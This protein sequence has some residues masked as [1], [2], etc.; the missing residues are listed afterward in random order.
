YS[1]TFVFGGTIASTLLSTS[2]KRFKSVLSVFKQLIIKPKKLEPSAA[3]RELVRISEVAQSSSKQALSSEGQGIGDGF[4]GYAMEMVGAGLDRD[5]IERALMTDISEV[6]RR[7]EQVSSTVR[8]MGTYAPMFGMTG[9]VIGV[10]QVL[11]N[12]TDID[13]IVAGMSL[14]LLTTLYGLILSSVIFIPSA[15]KLKG[16]SNSEL[17]TKQIIMEGVLAIM[18]KEIPLKVEKYLNAFLEQK[19]KQK[20]GE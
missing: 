6:K 14:A 2:F 7:H 4:L 5:F 12:V 13:T 9:T 10:T 20:K 15:S 1:F 8:S 3:V 16:M 18:D 17:I 19:A 11:Q